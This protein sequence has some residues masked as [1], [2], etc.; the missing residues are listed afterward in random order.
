MQV[1]QLSNEY[2]NYISFYNNLR[3]S[4]KAYFGDSPSLHSINI[5]S[6]STISGGFAVRSLYEV[7][8][9]NCTI[10]RDTCPQNQL[11]YIRD[12]L[13]IGNEVNSAL[14]TIFAKTNLRLYISVLNY[15]DIA[16]I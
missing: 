8:W 6:T 15:Q 12:R 11:N 7:K 4:I 16:L 14:N 10:P 9:M 5:I 2:E 13:L 1:R 3:N